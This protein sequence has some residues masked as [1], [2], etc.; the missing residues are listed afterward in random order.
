MLGGV[1]FAWDMEHAGCVGLVDVDYSESSESYSPGIFL[2]VNSP[3][4][5]DP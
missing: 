1:A 3:L 5:E 2:G 4:E